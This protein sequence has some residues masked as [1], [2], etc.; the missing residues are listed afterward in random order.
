MEIELYAKSQCQHSGRLKIVRNMAAASLL[1][2]HGGCS[3]AVGSS[4]GL[5]LERA[6]RISESV[7]DA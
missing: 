7:W 1:N 3:Q 6:L 2:P 5:N 4:L